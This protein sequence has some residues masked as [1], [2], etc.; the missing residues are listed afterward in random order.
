MVSILLK[1]AFSTIDVNFFCI[2]INPEKSLLFTMQW[3]LFTELCHA[4]PSVV[5][6]RIEQILCLYQDLHPTLLLDHPQGMVKLLDGVVL[7]TGSHFD[8]GAQTE[9]DDEN[10][11]KT[12]NEAAREITDTRLL[13]QLY[14]LK[15]LSGT[16]ARRLPWGKEVIYPFCMVY[17]II[18]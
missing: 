7:D 5:M 12:E 3:C 8:S 10:E 1:H 18:Q 9:A 4:S 17:Y 11:A 13:P 16:D 15:L 6:V 14:L 2:D